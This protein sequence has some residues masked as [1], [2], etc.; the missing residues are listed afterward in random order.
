MHKADIKSRLSKVC[1]VRTT[2][3][4]PSE[5]VHLPAKSGSAGRAAAENHALPQQR[6]WP[7]NR[8]DQSALLPLLFGRRSGAKISAKSSPIPLRKAGFI[9]FLAFLLS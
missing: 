6:K 1:F 8:T 2:A 7:S 4:Q 3:V 5:L 9:T